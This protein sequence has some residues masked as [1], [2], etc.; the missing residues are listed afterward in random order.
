M[1][2]IQ[3]GGTVSR[4]SKAGVQGVVIVTGGGAGI[5][6][7]IAEELGRAGAFVLTM[8]PMVTVDGRNLLEATGQTTAD[9]II[10][11]GGAARASTV[12]VTDQEAVEALFSGLIDEF[13]S[14]DAVINVAGITR[15]T[16]FAGGAEDDWAALLSVHLD[17]YLNVLRAALP[18]MA[19]AG[20]GRIIGVTSGAGWR[21]ANAGA[22]SCAKRAVAALTWQIGQAHP[23]G[24]TINALSPIAATRM[25]TSAL[26]RPT[27]H[28]AGAPSTGGLSLSSMPPPEHLGP[29]GSYLVSEGFS[30][31]TGQVLFSSGTE[32]ALIAP[33]RLLE[34]ARTRDVQSL[35]HA[36]QTFMTVAFASGEANQA[37]SGATNPRFGPIYEEE[38]ED[39]AGASESGCCLIVTDDADWGAVLAD[40]FS[41]RGVICVGVGAW[42]GVPGG[43]VEIAKGF[44]G[45]A[46]QVAMAARDT[47][48]DAV[49]VAL[50]GA[51]QALD[52][53]A[54]PN[55]WRQ[56]L[57]EHA[58]ITERIRTDAGWVRAASDY[59]ASADRPIRVVTI[60]AATSSA[61]RTRSQV[62][63]QLARGSRQGTADRVAAFS[64]AVETDEPS[65][66]RPAAELAAYLVCGG[67]TAALAGAELTTGPGWLGL[68]SHP[69][70]SGSISFGG[71]A[72]PGWLNGVLRKM[73][74]D[75]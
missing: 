3:L 57:D 40:A 55:G 73:T 16:D 71:P 9:R 50:V 6:A 51:D 37:S 68:R 60:T 29:I 41:S 47:P 69:T 2:P 30:W 14:L 56:I 72:V 63:A 36:L 62:A 18:A 53:A 21:P 39:S 52:N 35:P 65:E 66:R 46:E 25:V 32:V 11:A 49:V 61:G 15:P 59:S 10:A 31:C 44:T 27:D 17:G 13:G 75:R 33:P 64:I 74:M 5:G 38:A 22:Y 58:G 4:G 20:H 12:S 54:G 34:V 7:A 19:E 23:V 28:Q 70:A 42:P 24:V 48:L 8:D 67:D 43:P 26:S 45:A 1:R